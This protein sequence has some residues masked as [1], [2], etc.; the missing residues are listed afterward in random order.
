MAEQRGLKKSRITAVLMTAVITIALVLVMREAAFADNVPLEPKHGIPLVIVRIDESAEA[1]AAAETAS[2]NDYGTIA[3]MNS[4]ENHS[5]RC[6]GTVE[7]KVP[8]G[9][10]GEYGSV[11]VPDGEVS[12]D[13]IRGRGNSTWETTGH[14][15][16][17]YKI[18]YAKK[19]DLFGMG[20]NKEWALMANA[21]DEPS[22]NSDNAR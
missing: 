21:N 6:T 4:S 18:K 7:I 19:Q 5:V 17:P 16:K 3:E 14:T 12:L 2:G 22:V 13:F 1:I 9:Y 8:A 15:K 11:E 20:K 10:S